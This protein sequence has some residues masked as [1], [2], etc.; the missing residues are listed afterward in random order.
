MKEGFKGRKFS[1][2]MQEPPT[3]LVGQGRVQFPLNDQQLDTTL[4]IPYEETPRKMAFHEDH[5]LIG[6]NQLD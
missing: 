5:V 4:G 1:N 3:R 2:L 6:Q